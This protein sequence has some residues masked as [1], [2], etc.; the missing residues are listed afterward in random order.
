MRAALAI[1]L[2]C[3]S[4]PALAETFSDRLYNRQI[5]KQRERFKLSDLPSGKA[6]HPRWLATNRDTSWLE[7]A[8]SIGAGR[9]VSTEERAR[10]YSGALFLTVLGLEVEQ[11]ERDEVTATTLRGT[12]R[13]LGSSQQ[14]TRL[15]FFLGERKTE[16]DDSEWQQM[17]SGYE[18]QLYLLNQ[19]GVSWR[20][21]FLA[22]DKNNNDESLKGREDQL[23]GFVEYGAFR[24]FA[25]YTW[26]RLKTTD[27]DF[28]PRV[29]AL[30]Y[31]LTFFF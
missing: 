6:R 9:T 21:T 5:I 1:L 27:P 4:T 11:L 16:A 2:V 8:V 20:Q 25:R 18:A 24:L 31:G 7:A 12:L 10:D 13:V 28:E 14:N 30:T 15:N 19:L 17:V 23:E 3:A 29:E 26:A 22:A